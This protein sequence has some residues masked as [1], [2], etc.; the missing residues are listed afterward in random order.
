MQSFFNLILVSILGFSAAASAALECDDS[1]RAKALSAFEG[2]KTLKG[3]WDTT[4]EKGN[5]AVV[6]Y[7]I[8]SNGT[9]L[10]ERTI[11]MVSIYAVDGCSIVMTHYCSAGNQPRMR[12]ELF[13]DKTIDFK[14]IDVGNEIPGKGFISGAK[15]EIIDKNHMIQKWSW[16]ENKIDNELTFNLV[17]K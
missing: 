15:F 17:R 3:A 2:L 1:S 7:E 12:A 9:A 6:T 4:D 13:G 5:P 14:L 16:H 8:T 10:L 11:G